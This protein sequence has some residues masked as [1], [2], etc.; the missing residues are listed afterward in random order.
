MVFFLPLSPHSTGMLLG[1]TNATRIPLAQPGPSGCD[2]TSDPS[3]DMATRKRPRQNEGKKVDRVLRTWIAW[4]NLPRL[5]LRKTVEYRQL[6]SIFNFQFSPRLTGNWAHGVHR[7]K[8]NP[9]S[10]KA[11]LRQVQQVHA[12][13]RLDQNHVSS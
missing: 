5:T 3:K 6:I 2:I 9:L 1:C 7:S 10:N 4:N 11:N 8:S 12:S 13:A